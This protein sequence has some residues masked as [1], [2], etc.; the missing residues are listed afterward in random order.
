MKTSR[1]LQAALAM[2]ISALAA[3]GQAQTTQ[4]VSNNGTLGA[5]VGLLGSDA[6][7]VINNLVLLA[8]PATTG[9]NFSGATGSNTAL[10]PG[11]SAST[12]GFFYADFLINVTP[13]TAESITTTLTNT[14]GVANLSERIYQTAAPGSFLGDA[15]PPLGALQVWST[16]YSTPG[17]T[18]A[19]V[20]PTNLTAAGYYVVE[21]RGTSIGNFGGT[22][23]ITAVPESDSL[24]LMA[25]GLG[26]LGLVLARRRR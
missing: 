1:T 12:N 14:S 5:S 21:L 16:A 4:T 19:Y 23:S 18:Q 26:M 9:F 10:N 25:A 8:A 24:A 7:A 6:G 17:G 3:A 2:M 11:G 13:G 20:A 22:L 15:M